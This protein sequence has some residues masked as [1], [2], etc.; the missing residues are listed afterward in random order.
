MLLKPLIKTPAP[1]PDE[2]FMGFLLR[3][4]EVNHYNHPFWILRLAG[5]K[6][7]IYNENYFV[8]KMPSSLNDIS[9]LTNTDIETLK[10]LMIKALGIPG[11]HY[12]GDYELFGQKLQHIWINLGDVKICPDCLKESMYIRKI[13]S[14]VAVTACP[15]H[16]TLLINRCP[17]CGQHIGWYRSAVSQCSCKFDFRNSPIVKVGAD[18][19]RLARQIY[20][21]CGL[22]KADELTIQS[23]KNPLYSLNMTEMLRILLFVLCYYRNPVSRKLASGLNIGQLHSLLTKAYSTFENWPNEHYKFLNFIKKQHHN[24]GAVAGI[25]KDFG[26]YYVSL[27]VRYADHRFDFM[28]TAFESYL[29]YQWSGGYLNL[30][31]LHPHLESAYVTCTEAFRDLRVGQNAVVKY[32]EKGLL[33]SVVIKNKQR[34]FYLIEKKSLRD[35]KDQFRYAMTL[36]TASNKLNVDRAN[37]VKLV[38]DG[39]LEALRGPLL[40]GKIWSFKSEALNKLIENMTE[41]IEHHNYRSSYKTVNI[42]QVAKI[43]RMRLHNVVKAVLDGKIKPTGRTRDR[44]LAAFKFSYDSVLDYRRLT[45]PPKNNNRSL[46][47]KDAARSSGINEKELTFLRRKGILNAQKVGNI[48]LISNDE[49]SKFKE[50]FVTSPELKKNLNI[51]HRLLFAYASK[52]GIAPISGPKIDGARTYLFKKNDFTNS[53]VARIR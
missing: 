43:I 23:R 22:I 5:I 19:T 40:D 24:T 47:Q 11:G 12:V 49:W 51:S 34:T 2:S 4:T 46:T 15:I 9:I 3:A 6:D 17:N 13:W 14:V 53:D 35:L 28:R 38:Y 10:N 25:R 45:R 1:F 26:Q 30:T 33:N 48:Y 21:Y 42:Y 18:G 39:S 7:K 41:N 50:T 44:G 29:K 20:E 37:M 8:Y 27:Y 52:R 16:S 31:T 36:E 32:I